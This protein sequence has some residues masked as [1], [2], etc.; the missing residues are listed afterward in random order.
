MLTNAIG[1]DLLVVDVL[2]RRTA[3]GLIC[4]YTTGGPSNNVVS[5]LA[6][7]GWN[8]SVI[9]AIG[10]DHMGDLLCQKLEE[11]SI[12][13]SHVTRLPVPT[14]RIFQLV[15]PSG[16]TVFSGD[17]P[18]CRGRA[19]STPDIQG[20]HAEDMATSVIRSATILISD[21]ISPLTTEL[22]KVNGELG[23]INVL[24]PV[25]DATDEDLV[26]RML[27]YVH[28]V[29]I[30][31]DLARRLSTRGWNVS[32]SVPLWIETNGRDGIRVRFNGYEV[33]RPA[34]RIVE[35]VDEGGAGDAF[36]S[37]LIFKI[38]DDGLF[39]IHGRSMAK[40]EEALDC[41]QRLGALA[42][43]FSGA[44]GLL[45]AL[46]RE[47]LLEVLSSTDTGWVSFAKQY[48]CTPSRN[49][50]ELRSEMLDVDCCRVCH[51]TSSDRVAAE[52]STA[53]DGTTNES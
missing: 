26:A 19:R 49:A 20:I 52:I 13:A 39:D 14:R 47:D 27:K 46:D 17:C 22:A 6:V 15:G 41:S 4:S 8:C 48:Q 25:Y 53:V 45:S 23:G 51:L 50:I 7:L 3:G 24:D 29:K 28:I 33:V 42:C 21:R 31:N 34:H 40:I 5:Y 43:A 35:V 44:T 1:T 16:S 32:Q 38:F 12:A 10:S 36:V 37:A 30:G 11:L 2:V 9:G 18:G